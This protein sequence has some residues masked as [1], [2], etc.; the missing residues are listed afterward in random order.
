MLPIVTKR[1]LIKNN[2]TKRLSNIFKGGLEGIMV[3]KITTNIGVR[4]GTGSPLL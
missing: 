3:K 4:I 1:K 2:M